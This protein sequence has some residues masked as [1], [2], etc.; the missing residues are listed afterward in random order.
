MLYEATCIETHKPRVPRFRFH[1]TEISKNILT[2]NTML[3]FI[4]HLRDLEGSE[5][6]LYNKWLSDI[7]KNEIKSGF[8]PVTR[9]EKTVRTLQS[10]HA[11]RIAIYLEGWLRE[12]AIPGCTKSALIRHMAEK[13]SDEEITP[14]QKTDIL[15]T[16]SVDD[17]ATSGQ[18]DVTQL[19]KEAFDWVF[20]EGRP[21]REQVKLTDVLR[22]EESVD[23]IMD[24]NVIGKDPTTSSDEAPCENVYDYAERR[25]ASFTILGCLICHSYSCEHGDYDCQNLKGAFSLQGRPQ[26]L[27][28]RK[29]LRQSRPGA[30]VTAD[31]HPVRPCGPLCYRAATAPGEFPGPPLTKDE[32][33][34]VRALFATTQYSSVE[35]DPICLAAAMLDRPCLITYNEMDIMDLQTPETPNSPPGA[36]NLNHPLQV[37]SLSWYDR[38]RKILI[39]DWQEHTV[40]HDFPKREGV[41]PCFHEGP[42]RPKVCG[43][44]D[45]G[46]LCERFCRCTSD[47][48]A[49]KFTGCGCHGQGKLCQAKTGE[50]TTCICLQLNRECDPSLCGS[51]GSIERADP[52]NASDDPLLLSTGCQNCVLQRGVSK[53]LLLGQSQLEGVGYG[54]FTAQDIAQDAFVIE[55]VGELIS[56]DEGVRR[57]A[58][59]GDIFNDGASISYLFTLLEHD[60]IWVDAAIY[61]NLSRYINHAPP[62]GEMRGCNITPKIL[63][64]NGEFRIKFTALRDIK[65]GEELFFN[66]G[67]EFPNLT[68]KLLDESKAAKRKKAIA[69]TNVKNKGGT[70]RS[71]KPG[72]KKVGRPRKTGVVQNRIPKIPNRNNGDAM[73]I[74]VDP[75]RKRKRKMDSSSEEDFVPQMDGSQDSNGGLTTD[76]S[77]RLRTARANYLSSTTS[78]GIAKPKSKRGGA[79]PG[80]GRPRKHPKVLPVGGLKPSKPVPTKQANAPVVAAEPDQPRT[81]KKGTSTGSWTDARFQQVPI[82]IKD[83]DGPSS[84][85]DEGDSEDDESSTRQRATRMKRLPAKL[86]DSSF[87][88]G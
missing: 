74:D 11:K 76:G 6:E 18:D 3:T 57:E 15:N 25:L 23:T 65:A 28:M 41:E 43:C 47:I 38:H 33:I 7:E 27:L 79:R 58:R 53:A 49:Y 48:C 54:L 37:K 39:G 67:D 61:G 26:D 32:K 63:Y 24:S 85:D 20:V 4:P 31:E 80:S 88:V 9:E 71:S 36:S 78:P 86:R 35:R 55:Y 52:H 13:E 72:F 81:P 2:P 30:E 5:E 17:A 45:A 73:D 16:H 21:P 29:Q 44:V 70:V 1:H 59:R 10:E 87:Q 69:V 34:V 83:S 19:F 56:H 64:V 82:E 8:R 60:G 68:K 75:N 46:I 62:G 77:P 42:C 50:K 51:C 84:A 40:V 66:Y 22:Q 14:K 12:L